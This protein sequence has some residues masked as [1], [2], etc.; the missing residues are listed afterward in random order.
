MMKVFL[1]LLARFGW[2]TVVVADVS[3]F[4]ALRG[5]RGE[6]EQPERRSLAEAGWF[7]PSEFHKQIDITKPEHSVHLAALQELEQKHGVKWIVKNRHSVSA[8]ELNAIH[9]M[10]NE[11]RKDW[12]IHH[13][14]GTLP[15]AGVHHGTVRPHGGAGEREEGGGAALGAEVSEIMA[16]I[17]A[18]QPEGAVAPAAALAPAVRSKGMA[19]TGVPDSL[20]SLTAV[21]NTAQEPQRGAADANVE[22]ARGRQA[23]LEGPYVLDTRYHSEGIGSSWEWYTEGMVTADALGAHWV[24]SMIKSVSTLVS[25]CTMGRFSDT[26]RF[27]GGAD[28]SAHFT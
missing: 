24:G 5:A 1:V 20:A 17:E 3:M 6:E 4:G 8:S 21:R 22:L 13:K 26:R 25:K 19:T 27:G 28:R 16:A 12:K 14:G 9:E 11:R 2:L 15:V 23:C 10:L 18:P 7:G